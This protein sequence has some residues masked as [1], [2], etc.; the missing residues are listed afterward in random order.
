MV[1]VLV[2]LAITVFTRSPMWTSIHKVDR[3]YTESLNSSWTSSQKDLCCTS[4]MY[5]R[6]RNKIIGYCVAIS[7]L[8]KNNPQQ[9]HKTSASVL[10]SFIGASLI[11]AS[12]GCTNVNLISLQVRVVEPDIWDCRPQFQ[13]KCSSVE[14]LFII[15]Y[16]L[17][18]PFHPESSRAFALT[19]LLFGCLYVRNGD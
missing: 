5:F 3:M 14:R 15:T 4:K 17:T 11:R 6:S 8:G 7:S 19:E 1:C 12:Q 10:S 13:L 2:S 9:Y 16:W 18:A